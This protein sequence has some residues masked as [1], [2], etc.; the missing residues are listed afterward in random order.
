MTFII[1]TGVS[2]P[3]AASILRIDRSEAVVDGVLDALPPN[4]TQE[5]FDA[6][7]LAAIL[8]ELRTPRI[9]ETARAAF[10][11]F[12]PL[13]TRLAQTDPAAFDEI[14]VAYA[15]LTTELP[16]DRSEAIARRKASAGIR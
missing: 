1:D 6:G 3:D 13:A 8:G 10:L 9:L 11:R 16:V 14:I 12:L 2:R 15:E 4:P 5:Q 7:L